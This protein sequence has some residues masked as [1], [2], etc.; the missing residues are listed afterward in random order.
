MVGSEQEAAGA[1]VVDQVSKLFGTVTAVEPTSFSV[2][3]GALV[4][5]LGPSGSGKTT[6]LKIIA[7]FEEPSTGKVLISGA[8]VT[9]IP[10]HRRNLGFV[11]QQY[12]LFP[13]LTVAENIAYPLRM[14][15]IAGQ[16]IR[17]RVAEALNLIQLEGLEDRRPAQ[18]SGGQQQRVALARA[19][20]FRPPLLLMDE[21]MSALDKR[22]REEMQFEIRR[23]QKQLG[24]TTIAVT[25]DQTEAVVMS[26]TII[27]LNKGRIEQI[28]APGEVYR[29]P[30][31]EFVANFLGESNVLRGSVEQVGDG[32][33]LACG[34]TVRIPLAG[35]QRPAGARSVVSVLRP[36]C[37]SLGSP[38]GEDAIVIAG[39]VADTIFS[40][41]AVRIAVDVGLGTAVVAKVL[42][43]HAARI[44]RTGADV[45]INWRAADATVVA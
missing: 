23:L 18:L 13:H 43:N 27:V 35:S 42:S 30:R 17:R 25:H 44:P 19:I 10:S 38:S 16:E 26:D 4:T 37:I 5:L 1:V 33:V 24:I 11:F 9:N 31:S 7:G 8:D 45:T 39:R 15:R 28:G 2:S 29:R 6:I 34:P 41:E 20:V 40:G 36:E 22:L 14:R 32:L 21:P 12:A 3:E